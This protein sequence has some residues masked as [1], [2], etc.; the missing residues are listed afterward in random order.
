[1]QFAHIQYRSDFKIVAG[2]DRSQAGEMVIAPGDKEGGPKNRH[3]GADQWLYIASGEGMLTIEGRE[4]TLTAGML[5]LIE[6]GEAH[7]IKATGDK[8]LKTLNFYVPP[9]FD[10]SGEALPAG[11][12][13]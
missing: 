12:S 9:A 1:M 5:V 4:C 13:S 10:E 6:H 3:K 11:E 2:N 8:P 7:E